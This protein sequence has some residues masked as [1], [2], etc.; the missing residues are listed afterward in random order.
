MLLIYT[1]PFPFFRLR[2]CP[3][4]REC[5]ADYGFAIDIPSLMICVSGW[6][7]LSR[8]QGVHCLHCRRK[9]LSVCAC[10]SAPP[11]YIVIPLANVEC[12]FMVDK[13]RPKF[14]ESRRVGLEYFL[15]WVSHRISM[16]TIL[17]FS[18]PTTDSVLAVSF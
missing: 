5:S 18:R 16:I 15:K 14:L 9:A 17:S 1:L 3:G 13:F 6:L 7:I 4:L 8:M 11:F 10:G 2:L 12:Q